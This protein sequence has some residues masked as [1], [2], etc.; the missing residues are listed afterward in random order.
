MPR[1]PAL[2]GRDPQRMLGAR[3]NLRGVI[4]GQD[5]PRGLID[6]GLLTLAGIRHVPAVDEVDKVARAQPHRWRA[7]LDK[8]IVPS[9]A[10][11]EQTGVGPLPACHV[12][13]RVRH[14]DLPRRVEEEVRPLAHV[15]GKQQR[16]ALGAGLAWLS[17]DLTVPERVRLV[18]LDVQ[19][20]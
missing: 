9:R 8:W 4:A 20:L 2:L 19:A 5:H 10:R 16:A 18:V 6:I 7:G 11:D 15:V 13:G 3:N 12:L 17:A 14:V 1:H